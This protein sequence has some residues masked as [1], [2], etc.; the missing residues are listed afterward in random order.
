MLRKRLA[1][2]AL[3][4]AVGL[5]GAGTVLSG[6]N[7]SG[8][9]TSSDPVEIGNYQLTAEKL[10]ALRLRW[11]QQ[12]IDRHGTGTWAPMRFDLGDE[13]LALM[14]LPSK[15]VLAKH[16]YPEP[17]YFDESGNPKRIPLAKGGGKGSGDSAGGDPQ[18]DSAVAAYAGAGFLGIRPGGL[19]LTVTDKAIGWCSFAHVYGTPGSYKISTAGHCGKVGDVATVIGVI[20]NHTPVLIDIGRYSKSTG[21]GGIGKDWALIDIEPQFQDLVTPTM[22]GWGGPFGMYTA[23]GDVVAFN[24]SG[25]NLLPSPSVN[26]NPMLAQQNVHY[27]H[28]TGLG[29][30]VGTP[31]SGTALSWKPAYY[32]FFGAISPGDSGSGSNTVTGDTVG[33][34]REAAGINTH[35]YL[36]GIQPFKTGTGYLAGTRATLVSATLANGQLLPYPAPV[37]VAP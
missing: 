10:D 14:G 6:T 33:A 3:A 8:V 13:E 26:P 29:F 5:A 9:T 21:D 2:G 35:I 16:R 15:D 17:T 30:L 32:T 20:G 37:P 22:A 4:L 18:S 25:R 36:D 24:Y 28:G 31:R 19:L 12:L 7:A 23:T 34:Q 11:G 27:G 1:A